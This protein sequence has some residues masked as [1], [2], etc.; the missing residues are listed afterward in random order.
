MRMRP[1]SSLHLHYRL[2]VCVKLIEPHVAAHRYDVAGWCSDRGALA[3]WNLGRGSINRDKPDVYVDVDVALM[4]CAY[5]PEHPVRCLSH[6][7]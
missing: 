7:F 1:G 3:A 5:H 6:Q 4:S 2:C